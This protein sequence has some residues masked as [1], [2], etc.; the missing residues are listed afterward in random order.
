MCDPP[1][2][3]HSVASGSSRK[4]LASQQNPKADHPPPSLSV[5]VPTERENFLSER[6]SRG[7]TPD[8]HSPFVFSAAEPGSAELKL[9]QR[10]LKERD[11]MMKREREQ[12]QRTK[13]R[14]NGEEQTQPGKSP[15]GRA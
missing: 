11:D 4:L 2:L 12:E 7:H 5:F 9:N 15:P 14:R 3:W 13:T 8:A 1:L 10:E 6:L